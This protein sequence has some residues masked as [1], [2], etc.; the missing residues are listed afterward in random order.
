MSAH[1]TLAGLPFAVH[2]PS[3]FEYNGAWIGYDGRSWL[4]GALGQM[5]HPG[6]SNAP[7]GR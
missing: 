3:L 4:V 2:S 6:V 7:S 5:G 1:R